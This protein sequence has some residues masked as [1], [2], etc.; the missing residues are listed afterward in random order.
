MQPASRTQPFSITAMCDWA[1]D[2]E[3]KG[4]HLDLQYFWHLISFL[5]GLARRVSWPNQALK[6]NIATSQSSA[7]IIWIP[8]LLKELPIS[9]STINL[10]F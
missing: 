7:K 2:I 6:L 8:T 5:G 9:F 10:K 4:L 3:D 1:S